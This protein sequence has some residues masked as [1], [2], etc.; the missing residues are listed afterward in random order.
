MN[1]FE[2]EGTVTALG[3]NV[4]DNNVMIYAYIALTDT[5]GRRTMIEKVAVC[6]DIG[7]VLAVGQSGASTWIACSPGATR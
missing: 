6:N 1:L 5:A 7:S 3:Q 2:V 4:F